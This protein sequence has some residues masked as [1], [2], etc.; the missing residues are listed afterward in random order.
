MTKTLS[1][2]CAA[3]LALLGCGLA[4]A[5]INTWTVSGPQGGNFGDLERSPSSPN[6]FYAGLGHSFFRSTNGGRTWNAGF[7]FE[8]QV[9]EIAID[10][11]DGRRVY[12][13]TLPIGNPG[14]GVYRSEDGG[15]TFTKIASPWFG[16]WGIGVGGPD[17][18]T[19]YY[20]SA[21]REFVR[22]T[23]GGATWTIR[24]TLFN[25]VQKMLVDRNDPDRIV[26]MIGTWLGRSTDGGTTWVETTPNGSITGL[27]RVSDSVLVM[28]TLQGLYR[29]ADAGETWTQ[30]GFL[31]AWSLATD[32]S[33]PQILIAGTVEWLAPQRSIDGGLTWTSVGQPPRLRIV[34]GIGIN[35][36]NLLAVDEDGVQLSSDGGNTWSASPRGPVASSAANLFAAD[37]FGSPVFA[38]TTGFS[39]FSS[40]AGGPWQLIPGAKL[41]QATFVAKPD[42]ARTLY[43]S[44]FNNGILKSADGGNSWTNI[45]GFGSVD[46][47]LGIGRSDTNRLYAAIR[48]P[49]YS[50]PNTPARLFTTSNGGDSWSEVATNLPATLAVTKI[51]I[52][53]ADTSRIFVAAGNTGFGP[54]GSG[55]LWLSVDGGHTFT[56]RGFPGRDVTDIAIDRDDSRYV[57]VASAAG[58]F[59]STDGGQ[60]FT[61][62]PGF[63]AYS[64]FAGGAVALDPEIPSTVYASSGNANPYSDGQRTSWILRSVDR[65]DTWQVLRPD[66]ARPNYYVNRMVVDPSLP[67]QL[68]V[69]TGVHGVAALEVRTDLQAAIT[70]HDTARKVGVPASYQAR[71]TNNGPYDATRVQVALR[72]PPGAGSVR[73][74]QPSQGF[75]GRHGGNLDCEIAM[76]QTGATSVITLTYTPTVAGTIAARAEVDAHERDLDTANNTATATTTATP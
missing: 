20:S 74:S 59:T 25:N 58:F 50:L 21:S 38:D 9:T 63:M 7:H 48:W 52:D 10:P 3:V 19:L 6:T 60:T 57:Y 27:A 46:F 34:R 55:G 65:G 37:H 35:G 13:A 56:E 73:W 23:D 66:T 45:G 47:I 61:R 22:S 72:I 76:L 71:I 18:R 32:P 26:A 53:P 14:G 62:N 69:N 67:T 40:R 51:A 15:D 42:D 39:L 29:S 5:G 8:E 11:T 41:G 31:P 36:A 68:V 1:R 17:G 16:A 12:V 28:G 30:V 49:F 2:G 24:S 43:A 54:P 44:A 4:S 64:P 33:N 75:C 70:G